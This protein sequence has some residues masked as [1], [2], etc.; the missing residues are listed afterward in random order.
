[1]SLQG[2]F[3]DHPSIAM[4]PS[5]AATSSHHVVML[6]ATV[7]SESVDVWNKWRTVMMMTMM[8]S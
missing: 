8:M 4:M 2:E 3:H 6:L 5:S 7:D 1:L